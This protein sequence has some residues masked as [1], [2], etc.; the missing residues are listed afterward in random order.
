M[1]LK[2]FGNAG[3]ALI[4]LITVK[5]TGEFDSLELFK[6]FLWLVLLSKGPLFA[7]LGP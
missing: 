5:G 7:L 4:P 6:I 1:V 2:Y 3:T